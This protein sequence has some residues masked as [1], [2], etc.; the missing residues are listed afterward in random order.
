MWIVQLALRRPYTF[1]VVAL[2]LLLVTPFVLLRTPIDIFPSINIPIVSVIW[3]YP[4][5]DAQEV[6]QRLVYAHERA[7]SITVSD[8]EHMESTS[9]NGIGVI[10]IFLQPGAV[11][12]SAISQITAISQTVLRQMPAGQQPPL[13]IQYSASTVPILQYSFSSSKM[14]EQQMFDVAANQVRIGLA[15]VR[16]AVVP[17]PYGGKMRV[18][19]VDLN[20]AALKAKHLT[21]QDVVSAVNAQNLVLPGGT[22]KIGSTEYDIGVNSSVGPIDDLNNLPVKVVNGATIRERVLND[23]DQV[24]VGTTVLRFETS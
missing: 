15:T 12:S 18:I 2:L 24:V 20:L 3:Q 21:P 8:I 1:V 10:K 4:G 22:A 11:V 7:M 5:L 9:Y 16:G 17:W 19:S 6:E 13:I 23:G 14:S